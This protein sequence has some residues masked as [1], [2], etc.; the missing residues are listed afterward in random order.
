MYGP[1]SQTL[2]RPYPRLNMS[3]RGTRHT[4]GFMRFFGQMRLSQGGGEQRYLVCFAIVC[5]ITELSQL[6]GLG[7]VAEHNTVKSVI[8]WKERVQIKCN[9]GE[10][11][12]SASARV[13]WDKMRRG[14]L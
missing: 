14:S 5:C 7:D 2:M 8:I 12:F 6:L 4:N 11:T 1:A 9:T 13:R 10:V 3:F